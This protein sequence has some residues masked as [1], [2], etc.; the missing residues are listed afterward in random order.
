MYLHIA[1]G[2]L[3]A[4]F[5][6]WSLLRLLWGPRA[7]PG[8]VVAVVNLTAVGAATWALFSG[9]WERLSEALQARSTACLVFFAVTIPLTVYGAWRIIH[10]FRR[11]LCGRPDPRDVAAARVLLQ[12]ARKL[13]KSSEERGFG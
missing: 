11:R 2:G 12:G 10:D 8:T 13:W 7:G 4:V 9:H 3:L 5:A 1:L 6:L